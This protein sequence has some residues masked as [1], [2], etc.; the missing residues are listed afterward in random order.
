M[1]PFAAVALFALTVVLAAC[2]ADNRP[3][4]P[5]DA[6]VGA[7]GAAPVDASCELGPAGQPARGVSYGTGSLSANINGVP[8]DFVAVEVQVS[9]GGNYD[10]AGK[11]PDGRG[12]LSIGSNGQAVTT[13]TC[14]DKYDPAAFATIE[15]SLADTYVNAVDAPQPSPCQVTFT[16]IAKVGCERWE[17]TFAGTLR[18]PFGKG[19]PPVTVSNGRFSIVRTRPD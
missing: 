2:S 11:T 15:Y 3:V 14:G 16:S 4:S 1:P 12:R 6:G 5:V 19:H 9:R 10:F 17:G 8:I 7:D 18:D 13:Y